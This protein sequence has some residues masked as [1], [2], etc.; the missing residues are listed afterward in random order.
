MRIAGGMLAFAGADFLLLPLLLASDA[1]PS[2][3][4]SQFGPVH[5]YS[6]VLASFCYFRADTSL[7]WTSMRPTLQR[8][9]LH[10]ASLLTSSLIAAN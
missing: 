8:S 10:P 5:C 9:G 4:I 1:N 2:S 7:S 3:H 6:G